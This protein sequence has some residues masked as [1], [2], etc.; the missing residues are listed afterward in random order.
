MNTMSIIS[1]QHYFNLLVEETLWEH[2]TLLKV[3]FCFEKFIGLVAGWVKIPTLLDESKFDFGAC[4][5]YTI[6]HNNHYI[7][8]E[9]PLTCNPIT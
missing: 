1:F 4:L 8:S 2:L 6:M 9:L 7:T 3:Q 5:F